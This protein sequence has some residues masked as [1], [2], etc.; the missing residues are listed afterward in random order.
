MLI[1]QVANPTKEKKKSKADFYESWHL[2]NTK[3]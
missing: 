1:D 3:I 2:E